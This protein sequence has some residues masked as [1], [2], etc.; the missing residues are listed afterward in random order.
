MIS[1]SSFPFRLYEILSKP[2]FV[3]I[4]TWLPTGK[5]WSVIDPTAFMEVVASKYFRNQTKFAS[6]IRQ[7]NGW[8]FQRLSITQNK[9]AYYHDN[10]I[11]GRPDLVRMMVRLPPNTNTTTTTSSTRLINSDKTI[12][13]SSPPLNSDSLTMK[14][15]HHSN[16]SNIIPSTCF[17]TSSGSSDSI[18]VDTRASTSTSSTT[19]NSDRSVYM[20]QHIVDDVTCG[21]VGD[22]QVESPRSIGDYHYHY[23]DQDQDHFRGSSSQREGPDSGIPSTSSSSNTSLLNEAY[24]HRAHSYNYYTN[25]YYNYPNNYYG[26]YNNHYSGESR[27]DQYYSPSSQRAV[28]LSSSSD[29]FGSLDSTT[30]MMSSTSSTG[31]MKRGFSHQEDSSYYST[32]SFSYSN[33]NDH[34]YHHHPQKTRDSGIQPTSAMNSSSHMYSEMPKRRR[35][36][37]GQYPQVE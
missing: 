36:I 26:Y 13:K 11:R 9:S 22:H 27:Q 32:R 20:K 4:V 6:F 34:Y 1:S 5:A 3:D 28:S 14:S 18:I 24:D 30:R 23:H 8:G 19:G 12:C 15:G 10:F 37:T 33:T 35:A 7:V 29:A 21:G 31:G 16:T 2:E 17:S 25:T